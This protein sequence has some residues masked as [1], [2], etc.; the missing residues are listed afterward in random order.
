MN[1]GKKAIIYFSN[2]D[3]NSI[4]QRPQHLM[5]ELARREGIG[6]II[7]VEN[8]GARD[9]RFNSSDFSRILSRL[10]RL[11]AK[12]K[13]EVNGKDSKFPEK[14][15]LLTPIALPF[16][17]CFFYKITQTLLEYKLK[18]YFKR[19]RLNYSESIAWVSLTHP[20]TYNL[21]K[22]LKPDQIV[23][24]CID[25][26]KS[27][28]HINH[29]ILLCEE[30]F[31]KEANI[32][33]ATS[34][35]LFNRC[36]GINDSTFLLPNAVPA[37][38]I[39]RS[40]S[41]NNTGNS[42]KVVGYIGAIYSWFDLEL[43]H[44]CAECY[45]ET[46]FEIYGPVRVD[47]S[48]FEA[49]ENVAFMGVIDFLKVSETIKSFSVCLIPFKLNE[50][51]LHTNPVK[52]YEYFSKGKPVV[53]TQL[54]EVEKYRDVTFIGMDREDFIRKLGVALVED[55]KA[56]IKKRLEIAAQN[57]WSERVAYAAEILNLK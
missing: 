9:I 30:K 40:E 8:L 29:D 35:L 50:L 56:K 43:L 44:A 12:G 38:M 51:V 45:R 32:V 25:D 7:F 22:K 16:F 6:H 36:K 34:E 53:A 27:V 18:R 1:N 10:K 42:P 3:W 20:A 13:N 21:L 5:G 33:F 52:L 49:L 39:E 26:M 23:Y 15:M 37:A 48:K 14:I 2:I 28:T 55:D 19:F 57:T 4:C 11:F 41:E 24:D 17:N 47:I 46:R 31:V 54:P